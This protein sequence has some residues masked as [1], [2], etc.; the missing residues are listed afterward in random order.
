M[1]RN[2]FLFC[3]DCCFDLGYS[4]HSSFNWR[5]ADCR[6]DQLGPDIRLFDLLQFGSAFNRQYANDWYVLAVVMMKTSSIALKCI[7]RTSY[8]L[9]SHSHHGGSIP[10][11]EYRDFLLDSISENSIA[12]RFCPQVPDVLFSQPILG[13]HATESSRKATAFRLR[14]FLI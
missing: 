2:V 9:R 7:F 11:F 5:Q 13:S 14:Y 10:C 1:V 12:P 4:V 3:S 8:V 6:S